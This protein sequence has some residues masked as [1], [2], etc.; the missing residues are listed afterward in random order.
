M[1]MDIVPHIDEPTWKPYEK[2]IGA[3]P[4]SRPAATKA[5]SADK[6]P[7]PKGKSKGSSTAAPQKAAGSGKHGAGPQGA[8]A[9]P[10]YG[11]TPW[12]RVRHIPASCTF[13]GL[14]EDFCLSNITTS[15]RDSVA[16]AT[17]R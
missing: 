14:Q 10:A 5:P 4:A 3:Q 17:M 2:Q 1:L 16:A 12:I 7:A 9:P 11:Y 15:A 13:Q 6:Q 8:A